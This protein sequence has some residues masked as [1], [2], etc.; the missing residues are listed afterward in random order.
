MNLKKV[1]ALLVLLAFGGMVFVAW[2]G[3]SFVRVGMQSASEAVVFEVPRGTS[4]RAVATNLETSGLIRDRWTFLIAGKLTGFAQRLRVGEYQL[5]KKMPPMEIMQVISSGK[6]IA[7]PFTVQEG[8]NSFEIAETLQQQGFAKKDDFLR[9]VRDRKLSQ[10]L[11]GEELGSLEGYLFPETYN[12]TKYTTPDEI[13]EMMV[14]K[15]LEVYTEVRTQSKLQMPRHKVVILASIIEKE[16]GA[17]VERPLISSVFHNRLGRN[18]RLQSDPTIMYGI[19]DATGEFKKNITREDIEN[20]SAYNTYRVNG[21]PKGPIG[22]PGREALLATLKPADSA[23][24]YFVSRNDG[25]HV[26]SE[27][28]Q[29][30][31][32]AVKEFQLNRHAREGKSWR[33]LDESQRANKRK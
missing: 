20:H 4:F 10:R 24:L 27:T 25:T 7:H 32:K 15:F 16:T 11:L 21:L 8:L 29:Q 33:D 5:D 6:S 14:R 31:N 3:F 18:M 26:F 1:V 9:L 19:L 17:E 28:L 13:V 30:H 12:L 22:N 23:Y 2:Q